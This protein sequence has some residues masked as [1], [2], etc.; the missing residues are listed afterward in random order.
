MGAAPHRGRSRLGLARR[1]RH[2]PPRQSGARRR[3]KPPHRPA[4]PARRKG[5]LP[6]RLRPRPAAAGALRELAGGGRHRRPRHVVDA[7]ATGHGGARRG[8]AQH[9]DPHVPRTLPRTRRRHR[10]R[11]R[12]AP[13]SARGRRPGDHARDAHGLRDADV[14][15]GAGPHRGVLVPP[16][17]PAAVAHA[18]ARRRDDLR[19]AA[20]PRSR[21]PPRAPGGRDWRHR[22]RRGLVSGS[23]VIEVVFSWPGMGQL[24]Y[25]AALGRDLPLLLGGTIVA[26]VAVVAGNLLADAA[27]ALADPRVRM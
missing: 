17:P 12:A 5:A 10:A 16:A 27:Y 15:R 4:H 20:L 9:A 23:L 2:V 3:R 7:A 25:N 1:H 6:P 11:D 19:L 18:V 26:T 14:R 8:A 21:P 22:R 24:M 13:A